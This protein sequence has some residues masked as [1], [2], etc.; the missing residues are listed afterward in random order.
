MA[1]LTEEETEAQSHLV[2]C[3]DDKLID[4]EQ[5]FL[6]GLSDSQGAFPL[7][8]FLF[9]SGIEFMRSNLAQNLLE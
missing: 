9:L 3:Q 2:T 8:M 7:T 1:C 4:A 6:L 5:E